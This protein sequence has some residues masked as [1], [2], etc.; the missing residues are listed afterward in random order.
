MLGMTHC[1][2]TFTITI[3]SL[4]LIL[5]CETSLFSLKG[6][7]SESHDHAPSP[8][9]VRTMTCAWIAG[10]KEASIGGRNETTNRICI[11]G[12]AGRDSVG[13]ETMI[14]LKQQRYTINSNK[15]ILELHKQGR[16]R[17]SNIGWAVWGDT[18]PHPMRGE[19]S[20]ANNKFC[21]P[22]GKLLARMEREGLVKVMPDENGVY[23]S[24]GRNVGI[25]E[26]RP[27]EVKGEIEL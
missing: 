3:N 5:S 11:T 12:R 27:L 23:W 1:G 15:V 7:R 17:A 8:A 19:G 13:G 18:T 4:L 21:R 6:S 25:C 16:M 10:N 24:L 20:A 26:V 2:G 9:P 22:A 14:T